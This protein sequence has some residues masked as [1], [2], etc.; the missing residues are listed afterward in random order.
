MWPFKKKQQVKK[1]NVGKVTVQ[2]TFIDNSSETQVI[3]GYAD[4]PAKFRAKKFMSDVAR[5]D[6][7]VYSEGGMKMVFKDVR[8]VEIV[9]LEDYII[10]VSNG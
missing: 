3:S 9:K 2:I 5:K 8:C 7:R 1:I 10:E 6:Y 4:A